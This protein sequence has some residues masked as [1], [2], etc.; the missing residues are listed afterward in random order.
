VWR[1]A[2][3]AKPIAAKSMINFD[4]IAAERPVE[5]LGELHTAFE[6]ILVTQAF[7]VPSPHHFINSESFLPAGLFI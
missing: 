5:A 3:N 2:P 7:S 4:F 6:Q 1:L